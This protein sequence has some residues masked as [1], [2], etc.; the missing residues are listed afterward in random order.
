VP[1]SV[2]NIRA[3]VQDAQGAVWV[4]TSD[5]QVLRVNG[6]KLVGEAGL[7]RMVTS[8]VR[9]L[10]ATP[11]GSLWI[12]FADKGLGH[13]KN[14]S[15]TALTSARGLNDNAV[16][17]I[18]SDRQGWLWLAGGRGLYRLQVAAALRAAGDPTE[19]LRPMMFGRAEGVPNPQ[20]HYDN[21]PA[22]CVGR[23]GTIL[24]STSLGLLALH[25]DTIRDNPVLPTVTLEQV[26]VDDRVAAIRGSHFPLRV[27]EGPAP[28]DPA[29]ENARLI[30]PPDHRRLAFDFA[31]FSYTTPENIRYRYRLEGA[32]D[33]WTEPT[34]ELTARYSRLPAGDYRFHVIACNDA[35]VWNEAGAALA[36][37]V[38]PFLWQT[39]WFRVGALAVFT[40][41]V[42]AFVRLVSF[43]RLQARLRAA[44]QEKALL[45]ERTRIA[46][47]IHDDLGGSLTHI[48]LLSELAVQT[49]G[50]PECTETHMRQITDATQSVMKSLDEIV[51]AVNPRNDT[52]PHLISYLGQH[53]VE[54]LRAAGI[55][56]A[57]DLP[58][59]PPESA[60]PSDVRHHL[61]LVL[62]EALTNIVRH[63]GARS[64][65]LRVE[66]P[67]GQIKVN[68]QDNGRSFAQAPDD[69]LADGLRNMRQRIEALGGQFRIETKPGE[70]TRLEFTV[71]L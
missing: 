16:W 4:G 71:P 5:G 18:V 35:G 26:T 12:G 41:L 3:I 6:D 2:R 55:A 66:L 37:T 21:T 70:G 39:W 27:M 7:A 42:V 31:S 34:T 69:A 29:M 33:A 43:R 20:P 58:D 25:P 63:S 40:G 11:D 28:V 56:C 9:A 10:H 38:R 46:R 19:R 32:D 61:L 67:A 1:P 17:Q 30:L 60:V 44:E 52:L 54:F 24:F 22:V 68:V 14:G 59:N 36:V 23:N 51:W 50:L 15:Y 13:Y 62:K 65:R 64:V 49:P 48:K 57:V 8:S 47:D 45:Q 53:A